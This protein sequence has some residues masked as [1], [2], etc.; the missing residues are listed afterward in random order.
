MEKPSRFARVRDW[1]KKFERP[2]SSLSLIGGFVFDALTLKRVDEFWE[3][4][5]IVGHLLIV[6]ICIVL[7]NRLEDERL[8]ETNPEKVHF[9]LVNILQFFFGGLLSTYLVFYFRSGS[10]AVSW[11]F[12]LILAAAFI[13]NES[14]KKH[15][16]RLVFQISIF[17]LSVFLFS[18]YLVPVLIHSIGP[19]IFILS[20]V[21]S[22]IAIWIFLMFLKYSAKEKFN[23]S[24]GWLYLSIAGIFVGLNVLYFFNLIPPIP[25]SLKDAGIYQSLTVNAPGIYTV[26]EESQGFFSFLSPDE[27]IHMISGT[28]L[29]AYSAIFSPGSF[30]TTIIH[31]WQYYDPTTKKWVT[32]GRISLAV[33]GGRD[34]GYRTFSM[35][36]GI[37]AGKW[38]VDVETTRGQ[39]IGQL[40]FNVIVV[41]STPALE[42]TQID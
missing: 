18:I 13:A 22:L 30:N 26:Q 9:W 36:G 19:W 29:Y 41:S 1:Y 27:T 15:Y 32:K 6:A 5:W 12:F 34:G 17:F 16:S 35:E 14:L 24:K 40:G 25:L 38:R 11:P 7:I 10:L 39:I 21:A 2:I 4:F 8:D 20:G 33:I 3:N 37:T 42:T 31:D 23:K 28:P